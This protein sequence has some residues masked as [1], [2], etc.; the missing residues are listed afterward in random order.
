[1]ASGSGPA[2]TTTADRGPTDTASASP[3]PTS[4]ATSTQPSGGHPK[5]GTLVFAK[6]PDAGA[7]SFMNL[8]AYGSTMEGPLPP[9]NPRQFQYVVAAIAQ[10]ELDAI[11]AAMP[12]LY[13]GIIRIHPTQVADRALI[14]ALMRG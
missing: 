6:G 8:G 10:A 13:S 11:C 1:M 7:I 4:Q 12:P 2:S 9:D 3:W 14:D 5:D